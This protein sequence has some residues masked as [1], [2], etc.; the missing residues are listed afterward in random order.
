MVYIVPSSAETVADQ[1][2]YTRGMLVDVVC[3]S[4]AVTVQVRKNSPHHT[5][6]QWTNEATAGCAAF[7]EMEQSEG[8]RS[9]HAACPRLVASI[10]DAVANGSVPVGAGGADG[11]S[12]D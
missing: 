11:V 5:S 7:A 1:L 8:G 3:Q 10:D 2:L 4:C 12:D 9:V 6:I